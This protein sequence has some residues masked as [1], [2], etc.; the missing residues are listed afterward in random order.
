MKGCVHLKGSE[1]KLAAFMQGSNKRFAIPVYQRNYDWKEENCKQLFNDLVKTTKLERNS[2]FFGSIVS[3]FNPEGA[4]E[5]FLLIDGQQR[6]TTVSLL[7][8]AMYK[9]ICEKKVIPIRGSLGQQIYEEYLVDK[10]QDGEGRIKLKPVKNDSLALEKL[11]GDPIEFFKD[12]NLTINFNYFYQRIQLE[13]ITIDQLFDAFHRLEM[14]TIVLNQ[15]DNP[16]L[17]F[18]SL[19]STGVALNEGD[20]IRNFMLMG[21][22]NKI[23]EK[24]YESYWNP[25]EVATNY[26]VSSFIRDYL[27]VKCQ[28]IPSLQRVYLTF[29]EYVEDEK[30]EILPLL[31]ELLFYAKHYEILVKAKTDIRNLS[32]IISRLNRIET[33]V[34]RPFFLEVL[35]FWKENILSDNEVEQIFATTEHYIFRRTI[36]NL[37]TSSLNKIFLMLHKEIIRFDGTS[38][39]YLD[40]F[41]YA[42][43]NKRE[44]G[45][46]PED[47]EFIREL[48]TRPIYR[49]N[50]KNK[51][52]LLERLENAGTKEDK[53]IYRHL[54]QGEYSIEH[55]MPQHL[56]APWVQD[57]G[58]DYE[59]IHEKWVDR[60]ANL[61]LTAYNSEYS[62]RRF[63]EK[64][65]AKNGFLHSGIRMNQKIAQYEQWGLMELEERNEFLLKQAIS[66]WN[67]P[68]SS[69][70]PAEMPLDSCNLLD[71]IDLTGKKLTA[72]S[73]KGVQQPA[74]SWISM[75][76]QILR[77]LHSEDSSVLRKLAKSK[78]E[79]W[80]YCIRDV[81]EKF[82]SSIPFDSEIYLDKHTSTQFKITILRKVFPL[83]QAEAEDLVFFIQPTDDVA[84][85][86]GRYQLRREYWEFALKQI[87][88]IHGNEIFSNTNPTKS[89]YISGF[90]GLAGCN[91]S[92]VANY[93]DGR[94][95]LY[96]KRAT[97]QETEQLFH[98]LYRN[99]QEIEGKI[100]TALT[101]REVGKLKSASVIFTLEN[102]GISNREN[103]ASMAEFHSN[104]SKK[105]YDILVPYLR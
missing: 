69:Y 57:L 53:D 39:H 97:I 17:I 59:E 64:K 15:E 104:W 45:A 88:Q 83:F 77:Q 54:D 9:L 33:T 12:S 1:I 55:I 86:L 99:K 67:R 73:Y 18:E 95:E 6:L 102:S 101:W 38:E 61:T 46:F 43:T 91:I 34:A 56:N 21:E 66:I 89:S 22:T 29:K 27:S 20:K 19:N 36:C 23:Q 78:E 103:W 75:Y 72:F 16:Q 14:I 7:L 70:I 74:S 30:K 10:W 32:A 62:N 79:F 48:S 90:F 4:N 85:E 3:V 35:R 42:I 47:E 80:N 51:T 84:E 100:G 98:K 87:H 8:L 5:E 60:L 50:S 93:E 24:Y 65:N 63:Q 96:L 25:I 31:E 13:E 52:Y 94:V 41:F 76:E 58:E 105:F 81:P 28:A 40:K 26:Q 37:P 2:H 11:F 44:S 82:R 92:C 71:D 68:I 49:M